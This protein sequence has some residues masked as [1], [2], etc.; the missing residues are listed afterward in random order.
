MQEA[1]PIALQERREYLRMV[2]EQVAELVEEKQFVEFITESA[3]AFN[4]LIGKFV[5][6][7][8]ER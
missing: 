5:H 6:G 7:V 3:N 8:S 1:R 4:E 2:R